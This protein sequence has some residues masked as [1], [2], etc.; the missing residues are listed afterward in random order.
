VR[1]DSRVWSCAG[2]GKRVAVPFI[3]HR[4]QNLARWLH[5]QVSGE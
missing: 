5:A 3:E 4:I 2:I 1:L